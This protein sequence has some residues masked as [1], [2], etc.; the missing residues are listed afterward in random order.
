MG[1][2]PAGGPM[3]LFI[4]AIGATVLRMAQVNFPMPMVASILGSLKTIIQ[5]EKVVRLLKTAVI[6]S[7]SSETVYSMDREGINSLICKLNMKERGSEMK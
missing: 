1:L 2:E 5:M 7:V 6:T 3:V 4:K